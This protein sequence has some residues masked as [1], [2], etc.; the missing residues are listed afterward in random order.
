MFRAPLPVGLRGARNA[1]GVFGHPILGGARR[2]GAVA[3]ALPPLLD[4]YCDLE[5][6]LPSGRR[7]QRNARVERLLTAATGAAAALAVNNNA[8]ALLLGLAAPARDREVVV[9][10]GELVEIGGPFRVPRV[11]PPAG[12]PP[13]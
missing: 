6:D 9:S 10:R 11:L 7:G 2:P 8:A 1:T 5:I 13:G 4:A 3:A 12:A